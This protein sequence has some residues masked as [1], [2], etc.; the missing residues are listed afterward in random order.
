MSKAPLLTGLALATT[1]AAGTPTLLAR[2]EELR[3]VPGDTFSGEPVEALGAFALFRLATRTGRVLPFRMV[4]S[5]DCVRFYL[6]T[7]NHPPRAADWKDARSAV[8]AD[9]YRYSQQLRDG[10]LVSAEL[11][12]RPEPEFFVVVYGADGD[13]TADEIITA[14]LPVYPKLQQ[15]FPGDAEI[16]FFGLK[17]NPG[18]QSEMAVGKHLPWLLAD[19]HDEHR[20]DE[21]VQFSP[22][23]NSGVLVMSRDGLPLFA[24]DLAKKDFVEPVMKMMGLLEA[25]QPGYPKS[26]HDRAHYL[27]AIQPVIYANG[28]SDPVLVGNPLMEEGLRERHVRLVEATLDVDAG[29]KVSSVALNAAPQDV[30]PAMVA[31]LRSALQQ[32]CVFVPA[33]DHGK[34][35]DAAYHYRLPVRP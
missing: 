1:L 21:L 28:R 17:Y 33:V 16:V 20:M 23:E 5:E 6:Q 7:K 24:A 27:R 3:V 32:A 14:L 26:W 31:P 25:M 22:E 18:D 30:P 2:I 29:G 12:G 10:R 35:V 4:S 19:L 13:A 8:S 34:F 11:A 9:V 15:A